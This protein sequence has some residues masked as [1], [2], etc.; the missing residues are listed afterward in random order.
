MGFTRFS[1][2]SAVLA[3]LLGGGTVA[4]ALAAPTDQVPGWTV[5]EQPQWSPG[6]PWYSRT[7]VVQPT[8]TVVQNVP[9]SVPAAVPVTV[10]APSGVPETFA[11]PTFVTTF[12]QQVVPALATVLPA[13]TL[14]SGVEV[15]QVQPNVD[16]LVGQQFYCPPSNAASCQ[17]LAAQLAATTPGFTTMSLTGPLGPGVYVAYEA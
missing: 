10:L 17:A 16:V 9:V 12:Q 13:D 15:M 5:V 4:T 11:E 14:A 7:V 1:V 6:T 3:L 8:T 2:V